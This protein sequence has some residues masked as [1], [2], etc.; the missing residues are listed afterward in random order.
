MVFPTATLRGR[1]GAKLVFFFALGFFTL[2]IPLAFARP[3][4]T[5]EGLPIEPL[6]A[7]APW[8]T[9]AEALKSF[10]ERADHEMTRNHWWKA[11]ALAQGVPAA[12]LARCE[13]T[14]REAGLDASDAMFLEQTQFV[15]KHA[16]VD[17]AYKPEV[18]Q[19]VHWL[20]LRHAQLTERGAT[21]AQV[22]I[23]E[24]GFGMLRAQLE[25]T[26]RPN[27]AE[28]FSVANLAAAGLPCAGW[29]MEESSQE[30][31]TPPASAVL[32]GVLVADTF[33][34]VT[35]LCDGAACRTENGFSPIAVHLVLGDEFLNFVRSVPLAAFVARGKVGDGVHRHVHS[36]PSLGYVLRHS[37]AW[38]GL[39]AAVRTSPLGSSKLCVAG[40]CVTARLLAE[41]TTR[42]LHESD[43]HIYFRADGNEPLTTSNPARFLIDYLALRAQTERCLAA[44]ECQIVAADAGPGSL[45]RWVVGAGILRVSPTKSYIQHWRTEVVSR[46]LAKLGDPPAVHCVRRRYLRVASKASEAGCEANALY[47]R[48]AKAAWSSRNALLNVCIASEKTQENL[49]FEWTCEPGLAGV[50]ADVQLR[51]IGYSKDGGIQIEGL[52]DRFAVRKFLD[53]RRAASGLSVSEKKR[54]DTLCPLL[55][56][57]DFEPTI[58]SMVS[59]MTA[60]PYHSIQCN[61]MAIR[62]CTSN[63]KCSAAF[64]REFSMERARDDEVFAVVIA[65][66][67]LHNPAEIRGIA[68]GMLPDF[69]MTE[70]FDPQRPSDELLKGVHSDE[71][72]LE[73]AIQA[74][75]HQDH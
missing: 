43:D 1:I 72:V 32:G 63:A 20:E 67:V 64:E 17:V 22:K 26:P 51:A 70:R 21:P 57:P 44:G 53:A 46:A 2:P 13:A 12:T 73:Q 37:L 34:V 62:W 69:W 59:S 28:T 74:L 18:T 61:Q 38:D 47:R 11:L 75:Q 29:S 30:T 60:W 41:R 58:T 52:R 15:A 3:I 50:D 16:V 23:R 36:E 33:R 45:F 27:L 48:L 40:T 66:T 65:D 24:R 68:L 54:A 39:L 25:R 42:G 6:W 31:M 14:A 5:V 55:S 19:P 9:E 10:A 7:M 49:P 71:P 35:A 8:P 4:G 56:P